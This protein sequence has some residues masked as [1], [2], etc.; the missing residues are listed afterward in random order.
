MQWFFIVLKW[1]H[2]LLYE[3][4]AVLKWLHCVFSWIRINVQ[5]VASRLCNNSTWHLKPLSSCSYFLKPNISYSLKPS[6]HF[7]LFYFV[8]LFFSSYSTLWNWKFIFPSFSLNPTTFH[9]EKSHMLKTHHPTTKAQKTIHIQLLHNY[10]LI[11]N[12]GY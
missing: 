7:I 4:D 3:L 9:Y 1:L 2:V 11:E 12:M 10:P 6:F 8:K 5:V